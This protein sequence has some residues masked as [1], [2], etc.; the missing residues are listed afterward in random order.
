MMIFSTVQGKGDDGPLK[1]ALFYGF[2]L[3]IWLYSTSIFQILHVIKSPH[4]FKI[5]IK[6]TFYRPL[7]KTGEQN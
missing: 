6:G 4:L 7:K 5:S 1:N 2:Y 3:M